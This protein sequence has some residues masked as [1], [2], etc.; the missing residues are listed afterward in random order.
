LHESGTHNESPEAAEMNRFKLET[1]EKEHED[2][3]KLSKVHN[4]L[5]FAPDETEPER[6]DDDSGDE[7][8]KYGPEIEPL[9]ERDENEGPSQQYYC[10]KHNGMGHFMYLSF[11]SIR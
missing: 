10:L 9:S 6:T 5:S 3:P 11:G 7:V 1:D 2:D 8:S 4:L